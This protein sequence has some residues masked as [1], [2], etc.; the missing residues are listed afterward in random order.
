MV[1]TGGRAKHVYA[2]KIKGR[3]EYK[4]AD[5]RNLTGVN[6]EMTHG[7]REDTPYTQRMTGGGEGDNTHTQRPPDPHHLIPH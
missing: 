4:Q 1:V 6:G 5:R 3:A 7:E 2:C